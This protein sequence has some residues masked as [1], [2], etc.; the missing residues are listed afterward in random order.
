MGQLYSIANRGMGIFEK[1]I[2]SLLGGLEIDLVSAPITPGTHRLEIEANVGGI[3][4]YLPKYVKYTIEGGSVIGG[5]D[6]HDGFPFWERVGR[7]IAA[8]ARMPSKIPDQAI[9]N[10]TP[11]EPI[12]IHLVIDGGIGGVDIYRL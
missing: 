3:E 12:S 2:E 6:V 8:F 7:K 4:I 11:D 9:A 5:E 10:P 1:P